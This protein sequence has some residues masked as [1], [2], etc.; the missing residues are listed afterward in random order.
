MEVQN[1]S[2]E[3]QSWCS[4]Q[5]RVVG[6]WLDAEVVPVS[7]KRDLRHCDNWRGINL[8]GSSSNGINKDNEGLARSDCCLHSPRLTSIWST[9]LVIARMVTAKII[10]DW[11]EVISARVLPESQC[12]FTKVRGCVGMIS[13]ALWLIDKAREHT[14][15]HTH[16]VICTTLLT[17]KP[18]QHDTHTKHRHTCYSSLQHQT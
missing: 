16:N 6:G 10:K 7:K 11:L 15:L 9:V 2:S 14:H 8:F 4:R 3:C 18:E 1:C 17:A 5:G 13:V 12:G